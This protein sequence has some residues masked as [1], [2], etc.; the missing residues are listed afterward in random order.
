MQSVIAL[1]EGS[2]FFH[3]VSVVGLGF[4]FT[5][6]AREIKDEMVVYEPQVGLSVVATRYI[7]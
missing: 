7:W 4:L 1:L 5:P 2:L 3:V 6:L